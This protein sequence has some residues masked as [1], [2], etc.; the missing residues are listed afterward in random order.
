MDD[1]ENTFRP[2][3]FRCSSGIQGISVNCGDL[4][5]RHLDCQWI[6]ITDV[7][8]GTYI[9]RQT[10]NP[11]GLALESDYRNNVEECTVTYFPGGYLYLNPGSCHLSGV[12]IYTY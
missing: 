9:L 12:Y 6:D 7:P 1:L 3:R 10:V 8:T 4:Y 11:G 2:C 5:S